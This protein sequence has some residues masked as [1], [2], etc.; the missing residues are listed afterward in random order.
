MVI[1]AIGYWGIG[2][3]LGGAVGLPLGFARR[4]SGSG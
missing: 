3:P 4:A 1:A 2:L